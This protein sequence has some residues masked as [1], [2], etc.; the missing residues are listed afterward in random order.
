PVEFFAALLNTEMDKTDG[1]VKYVKDAWKHKIEVNPPHINQS[2]Y[3]FAVRGDKI[4]FSLGA[5]KGVGQGAAEAIVEARESRESKTFETLEDFFNTV[6]IKRINK[7]TIE[8]LIKAGAFDGFG[9]N[10]NELINGYSIFIDRADK[11]R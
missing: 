2:E 10:R 1:I 6:D 3:R 4:Y 9:Y 8:A 7:K 5:I 11:K